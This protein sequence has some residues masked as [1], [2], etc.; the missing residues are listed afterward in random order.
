MRN[1]LPDGVGYSYQ[2]YQNEATVRCDAHGQTAMSWW[3]AECWVLLPEAEDPKLTPRIYARFKI[4]ETLQ[5]EPF[6]ASWS[7]L[8]EE[9]WRETLALNQA[10]MC[11]LQRVLADE[12]HPGMG[13]GSQ[14]ALE[15][16]Q[17]NPINSLG[18]SAGKL[19]SHWRSE[20]AC[21][22]TTKCKHN[23]EALV[24]K[25]QTSPRMPLQGILRR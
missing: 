22:F 23:L 15:R 25:T 14:P 17:V 2:P 9:M 16:L 24:G 1:H 10:L 20:I 7:Q 19:W 4:F 21:S 11:W 5:T 12:C 8:A 18:M 6:S 13:Y 3:L